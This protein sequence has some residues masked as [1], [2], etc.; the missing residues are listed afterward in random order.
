M[1]PRPVNVLS[2]VLDFLVFSITNDPFDFYHLRSKHSQR[3]QHRPRS[4]H[5]VGAV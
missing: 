1:H 3:L 5:F 4:R 2:K